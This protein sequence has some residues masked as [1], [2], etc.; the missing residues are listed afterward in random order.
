[1]KDLGDLYYFLRIEVQINEKGLFLNQMKY[2]LD[3]LQ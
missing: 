1:M 3:L 2:V